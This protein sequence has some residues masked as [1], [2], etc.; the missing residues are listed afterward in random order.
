MLLKKGSFYQDRLG[1]SIGNVETRRRFFCTGIGQLDSGL[2]HHFQ[3]EWAAAN[4]HFL[5]GY[6]EPDPVRERVFCDAFSHSKSSFYRD[7]LRTNIVRENS[8]QDVCLQGNGHNHPHMVSPA[9]AAKDWVKVQAAATLMELK[10]VSPAVSTT[11]LDDR[12]VSPWLD[13]FFGNCSLT[14]GCD[15]SQIE[16]VQ[17]LT[18]YSY[19]Y[20]YYYYYY[21]I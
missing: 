19:Y 18:P 11:G 14:P 16:C 5:L 20:S 21:Y 15:T 1:T 17:L 3:T 2:T 4:A 10:L 7:R 8:K 12:G 9:L 13:Q 6:N